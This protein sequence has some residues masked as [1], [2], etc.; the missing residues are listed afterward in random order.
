MR[1]SQRGISLRLLDSLNITPRTRKTMHPSPDLRSIF[2]AH[3]DER[4]ERERIGSRDSD[5]D[6]ELQHDDKMLT[7]FNKEEQLPPSWVD[8]W[9][10]AALSP[11][12]ADP[13]C[14]HSMLLS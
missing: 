11:A 10:A 3:D 5:S 2:A 14:A 13:R 9:L 7:Q 4:R 1:K 12:H 6:A 8:R